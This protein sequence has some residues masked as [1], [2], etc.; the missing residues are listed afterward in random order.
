[1]NINENKVR[2]VITFPYAIKQVGENQVEITIPVNLGVV[3]TEDYCSAIEKMLGQREANCF[4]D[5]ATDELV[6]KQLMAQV[7]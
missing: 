3:F 5:K 1:M 7:Y 6:M 2:R 4:L